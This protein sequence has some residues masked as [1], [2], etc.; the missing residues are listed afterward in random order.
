MRQWT[1]PPRHNNLP[2]AARIVEPASGTILVKFNDFLSPAVNHYLDAGIPVFSAVPNTS[3]MMNLDFKKP[4]C[5]WFEFI[6]PA[7]DDVECRID[8]ES[9]RLPVM[10]DNSFVRCLDRDGISEISQNT[11]P[12]KW[13]QVL[14]TIKSF[15]HREDRSRFPF[16][17]WYGNY[18]PL[19]VLLA[20]D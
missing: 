10:K 8:V 3:S 13:S 9:D 15:K 14:D 1:E 16:S 18:K 2:T 11:A 6:G 7:S 20:N 19:F 5:S 17:S 12:R 4:V